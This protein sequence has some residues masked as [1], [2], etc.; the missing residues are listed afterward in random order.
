[1]RVVVT[2]RYICKPGTRQQMM[3]E[4]RANNVEEHFKA[5]PENIAYK[6]SYA[7]FDEDAI[8]LCDVWE[9]EEGFKRH[10][11]DPM[12]R[13]TADIR[14]KYVIDRQGFVTGG[15]EYKY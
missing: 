8:D 14:S 7:V 2:V 1:M 5:Y 4:I 10:L 3:E 9:N 6:F 12:C 11:S 13:I 15:E